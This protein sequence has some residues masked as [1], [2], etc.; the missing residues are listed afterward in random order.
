[1]DSSFKPTQ[2]GAYDVVSVIGRSGVSTVLKATERRIGRTVAIKVLTG[3]TDEPDLLLLKFYRQA[4]DTPKLEHPNIVTVYELDYEN[5]LPYVVMEYLE[6]ERL[7]AVI[8]A[9]RPMP[10]AERLG[11]LMHEKRISERELLGLHEDKLNSVRSFAKLL[12]ES[13]A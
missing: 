8:A 9:C 1:M 12:T 7:D 10:I 4:K 3:A 11:E 13:V 2:I 5:G 6:G